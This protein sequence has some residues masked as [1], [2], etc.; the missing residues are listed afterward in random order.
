[1]SADCQIVRVRFAEEPQ[2]APVAGPPIFEAVH[3]GVG[4]LLR[5]D[6]PHET[7]LAMLCLDTETLPGVFLLGPD[8]GTAI[9]VAHAIA[10]GALQTSE[11]SCRAVRARRLYKV[12]LSSLLSMPRSAVLSDL[13]QRLLPPSCR[14]V[15]WL[16]TVTALEAERPC[17]EDTLNALIELA[18]ASGECQ[19]GVR[20]SMV[21]P[22]QLLVSATDEAYSALCEAVPAAR[23]LPVVRVSTRPHPCRE[24]RLEDV[25]T[26]LEQEF[27]VQVTDDAV[28]AAR[29]RR[30]SEAAVGCGPTSPARLLELA[31]RYA[32]LVQCL[33][34]GARIGSVLVTRETVEAVASA[35]RQAEADPA[36]RS[37]F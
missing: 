10:A 3:P 13:L 32:V 15:L 5:C 37:F 4:A 2:E 29:K 18:A 28:D 25:R 7:A 21:G 8:A 24:P 22:A 16:D 23:R 1:M 20:D 27:S 26:A 31:A 19:Q 11:S 17:L 35:C 33:G 9:S 34:G 6:W 36:P 30:S 12:L 14:P